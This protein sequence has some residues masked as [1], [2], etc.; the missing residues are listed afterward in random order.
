VSDKKYTETN[1]GIGIAVHSVVGFES[2]FHDGVPD[3]FLSTERLP[4]G[5]Y[6][7]N[8]AASC[9]FILRYDGTLIQMYPITASTWTSGG[10]EAN[11]SY[12]PIELEGGLNPFNEP[13]RPAQVAAF[14]RLVR[15]IEAHKGIRYVPEVS[16]L[17][18]KQLAAKFGYAPTACASDRYALGY[19]ALTAAT[20]PGD[21]PMT[22]DQ[23]RQLS[24]ATEGV[25]RANVRIDELEAKINATRSDAAKHSSLPH[26]AA[27]PASEV[28]TLTRKVLP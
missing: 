8:A 10:R 28:V 24:E 6:T 15:D 3:R 27:L 19:A 16:I 4:N 11:T 13:M 7:P 2:T 26:G 5:Q 18:H 21:V 12:I 9:T 22:P 14:V 1:K 23:I 20:P 25:K 17:Q